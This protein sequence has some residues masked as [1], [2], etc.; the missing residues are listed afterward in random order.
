MEA[1]LNLS[2]FPPYRFLVKVEK[3]VQ[4]KPEELAPLADAGVTPYRAIKK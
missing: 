4:I 3:G 1:F 2:L